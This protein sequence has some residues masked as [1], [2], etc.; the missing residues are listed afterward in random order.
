MGV[1]LSGRGG[2]SFRRG[3]PAMGSITTREPRRP[4]VQADEVRLDRSP[5]ELVVHEIV[6][7]H[8]SHGPGESDRYLHH[9]WAVILLVR[10][11]YRVGSDARRSFDAQA[12]D[13]LIMSPE[14]D[15]AWTTV[16][17]A[18]GGREGVSA[19]FALFRPPSALEL[20]LRY[21][22]VQPHYSL[23]RIADQSMLRRMIR[24][25]KQMEAICNSRLPNR[26]ALQ[27]NLLEQLL[28]WCQAA[29]H[30]RHDVTDRRVQRAI[31]FLAGNLA[32]EITIERI[33]RVARLSRSQ[34]AVLFERSLGTSPMRYLE[35]LRIDRAKQLLRLSNQKFAGVAAAVGFCDAKYL[36]HRFKAVVGMTPSEYRAASRAEAGGR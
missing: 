31:E 16:G 30:S 27:F 13:F 5:P 14:C 2:R 28:L 18:V 29:Q 6:S 15:H 32:E 17:H 25:F 20:L 11:G 8:G 4:A 34:L 10:G 24:C 1:D 19:L 22:E 23:L 36:S 3:K 7:S 12:G 26:V 9:Q 35:K 33:C 21:P